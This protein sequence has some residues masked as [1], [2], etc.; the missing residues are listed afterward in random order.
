M[1]LSDK[2]LKILAFPYSRYQ[3]L[4]CDGSIRSG[5]TS[6][7][8][9]A[10]VDWAMR[11]YD[12]Q[13]FVI[14][15]HTVGSA[16]RNV[17]D[18][19]MST[20]YARERYR[21][22]YASAAGVLT[23]S[24]NGRENY[25]HVFGA[26]TSRSFQKVQGMTAAGLLVDEVTLCDRRAVEQAM[27]RCSVTGSRY[28]FNCNPDS[29]RHWF[30]EE[31][32]QR[33]DAMNALHLHFTLDDNPGLSTE[34]IERYQRQYHG[35][36]HDRYIKGLWVV[37]EGL[38]YQLDGVNWKCTREEAEGDGR[39]M[40][41]VSCDYG[42]TNPFAALLWR[43]TPDC[44][45]I[46]DEYYFDSRREGRRRTDAEH[47]E[48][49]ERLVGDRFIEYLVI[50]PSA[51]SF[52]EEVNRRGRFSCVD[53]DNAVVPGISICDQMLHGGAL[54]VCAECESTVSEMG[55]YRWDDRTARDAVVK[56]NDH[57]MDAMRY[58]ASTVLKYELRG[59]AA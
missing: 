59:F 55:L 13:H 24:G 36:F 23:V 12:R 49:L 52:K 51:T 37:A 54:K 53:A 19:Y 8:T 44:A 26:D 42:I 41:F 40:W 15:G 27:A 56:E 10:F 4:I 57:A 50:D 1:P 58:M 46:V 2:Q 39:G 22:H 16:A 14:M 17:V 28:W 45:Y 25:F 3:A 18:P 34:V 21:L 5:K 31:W 30:F 47:Y 32:V 20:T 29:P 9:L 11:E 43:V 38:V 35:V 7:M 48:A 6:V 33:A